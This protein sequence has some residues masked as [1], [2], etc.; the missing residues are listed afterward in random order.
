[1]LCC[2]NCFSHQWLQEH[3]RERNTKRD[4]CDFCG[5]EDVPVIEPRELGGLFDNLLSMYEVA[6]NYDAGEPLIRLIQWHWQVFDEE[7]LDE[8]GQVRLLEEIAN[9]D[10]DD[11]DGEPMLRARELY[12]PVA[13]RPLH[14]THRERW[15]EFCFDV[16]EDPDAPLPFEDYFNENFVEFEEHLPGG[17]TLYRARRGFEPGEYEERIPFGGND[18]GAPPADRAL[19]GRG[20]LQGQRVLYCA[21]QERTAVA[22]VRPPFGYYVSVAIVRL[23][24]ETSILDLTKQVDDLNPFIRESLGWDVEIRSLLDGFGEEMSRPLERDDDKTHY[25]PC[26]R[27]AEYIRDVGYD[28]IRY[29]SAVS[30]DGSNIVFFDPAIADVADSKLVKITKVDFEYGNDEA[31]EVYQRMEGGVERSVDAELP[32]KR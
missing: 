16:R 27:L 2:P 25:V 3:I 7:V 12:V 32:S 23:N 30:P 20:N 31:L 19:A 22:E 26:Q 6:D 13:L 5:T 15:E 17:T 8:D 10:W 21:D 9:S 14:T 11:D 24:R 1:M 4:Q 28:G 29:P 18:I